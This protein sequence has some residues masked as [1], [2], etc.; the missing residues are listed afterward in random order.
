MVTNHCGHSDSKFIPK[1]SQSQIRGVKIE[2]VPNYMN[3]VGIR[4]VQSQIPMVR[5]CKTETKIGFETRSGTDIM[6]ILLQIK[7]LQIHTVNLME[8]QSIKIHIII[9]TK[10]ERKVLYGKHCE[11]PPQ[12]S[13]RQRT[14]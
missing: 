12:N 3:F 14:G 8:S 7:N 4:A 6:A 9:H 11:L 13:T 5:Q 2:K 10:N 1:Y